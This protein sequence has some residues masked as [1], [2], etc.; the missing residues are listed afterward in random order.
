[1]TTANNKKSLLAQGKANGPAYLTEEETK[2]ILTPFAFKIDHSLFG[3]ALAAPWKRLVA[4]LIDL[5]LVAFLSDAP[6]ELLAIVIAIT[7][8]RLGSK[9]RAQQ[10]G[11]VKGKKRRAFM[12]FIGAFIILV[13]LLDFLPNFF[14]NIED[15]T[16]TNSQQ[17]D[18]ALVKL[19]GA[20]L[21]LSETIAVTT[22]TAGIISTISTSDCSQVDCWHSE[23]T[24]FSTAFA[25]LPGIENDFD[26]A[27]EGLAEGTE[28][29]QKD[30]KQLVE[31][32]RVDY[33]MAYQQQLEENEQAADT[34]LITEEKSETS[35][36]KNDKTNSEEQ[37]DPFA[38][39]KQFD[40]KTEKADKPV[41]SLMKLAKG[42]IDD[43]GLGFGWAAFYFT[44]F[45]ALWQGQ[46]PGKK[47]LG[48]KVLQLDGTP[49]SIWDSFG[50]Y[51]GYGAGIATGL[52]GFLQIFWDANRQAIHDQISATVVIDVRSLKTAVDDTDET[53]TEVSTEVSSESAK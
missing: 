20:P 13:M 24:K 18:N 51:G 6:G 34:E 46:T 1:M 10:L 27:I 11:K 21:D 38:E 9:K 16:D 47:L 39:L 22:L 32:L 45:T 15:L 29:S 19:K 23:L 25:S 4:L 28:L 30:Q 8:Y 40:E 44:V 50:R 53:S 52:L 42:I 26:D 12:R 7:F 36:G 2:Q 37:P 49:L 48:I 17:S 41:Y 5:S 33:Q 35:N 14:N 3:L 31:L 43:L